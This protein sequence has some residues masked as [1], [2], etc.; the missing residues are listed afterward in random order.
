MGQQ[1]LRYH[2]P[3]KRVTK[4][5]SVERKNINTRPETFW[6]RIEYNQNIVKTIDD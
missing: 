5:E 4:L 1:K 2:K 3:I 6:T